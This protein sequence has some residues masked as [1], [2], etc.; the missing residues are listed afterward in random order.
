[1][2]TTMIAALMLA[3]GSSAM[4]DVV[5]LPATIR[6]FSPT[7]HADFEYRIANDRNMVLTTL[8]LDGKPVYAGPSTGTGTTHGPTLFN[9][10]FNDTLG[11]NQ[12]TGILIPASNG[13]AAPGGV[14]TYTN[15]SF[16]PIDGQLYG[17]E[18][19]NHNFHFTME[20]ALTFTYVPGQTFSFSGDDDVWVFINNQRVID[21]GGVHTA[22]SASVNLDTL[23]L[24]PGQTYPF[25]LFFAERHTSQSNF[26]MQ[27]SIQLVPAPGAAGV[28]GLGALGAA[29]RRRR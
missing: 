2:K 18:G 22:Q 25:N 13:A 11:I 26:S 12:T 5:M 20:M 10:W 16:F 28:L 17:N 21:L 27:T 1:M 4:A 15:N 7:T 14:Y 9:Q 23:G 29:R 24:T 8:G 19:R 3:A 6:D